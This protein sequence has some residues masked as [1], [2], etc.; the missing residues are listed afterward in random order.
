MLHKKAKRPVTDQTLFYMPHCPLGLYNNVI[1][2]N[3]ER[4]KLEKIILVGN[5]LDFYDERYDVSRIL[6]TC[7]S[8]SYELIGIQCFKNVNIF[9]KQQS[10]LH[11]PYILFYFAFII[12]ILLLLVLDC[13]F[14]ARFDDYSK[15]FIS[16]NSLISK[17]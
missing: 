6:D 5:R 15:C 7:Y 1:A 8:H 14:L 10:S 3:W 12:I 17:T 2:S 13:S 4:K 16:N 11:R 9:S